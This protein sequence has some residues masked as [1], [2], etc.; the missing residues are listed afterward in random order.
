M[1]SIRITHRATPWGTGKRYLMSIKGDGVH[2]TQHVKGQAGS[3][4]CPCIWCSC[5]PHRVSSP[6]RFGR[7]SRPFS[8][9]SWP[10]GPVLS[11]FGR[12]QRPLQHALQGPIGLSSRA[13][14]LPTPLWNSETHSA[15]A[16]R[17]L[18]F[19]HH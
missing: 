10:L 5:T 14:G 8:A 17:P 7:F 12:S 18:P 19:L 15:G 16:A 4:P 11:A 13:G 2:D 1:F 6:T 9:H 3:G